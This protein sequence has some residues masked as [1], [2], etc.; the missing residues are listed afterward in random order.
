MRR[1][2]F[3]TLLGG[4]AVAWPL[5]AAAQDKGRVPRI[6]VLLWGAPDSDPYVGPLRQGLRDLGYV[7]G[8]NI[9]VEYR[10]AEGRS[11]RAAEQVAELVHRNVDVIV[12][13]TTPAA[14]A[15]KSGT[16][17][18]PIVL[19]P[20]ADPLAT[21]LVTSLARPGGNITGVSSISSELNAKRLE[22]LREILP[23]LSRMAFLGSKSDPNAET[24]LRETQAAA[25]KLGV[26]LQPVM[27]GGP[28][29][30]EGAFA[31]MV[32]G[33]AE[34][35]IVQPIF[36]LHRTR[37]AE[38]AA[39]HRLPTA[40]ANK[41]FAEAGCL[42][43]FGASLSESMRQAAVCVDKILKG[44]RPGELPVEQ[45]TKFE[46]VINLKTAKTLG[47]EIPPALLARADEVID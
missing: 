35:L 9:L 32:S 20:V 6:G 21:G 5:A 17:T 29:E 13:S 27:V 25:E 36:A 1:R 2:E 42:V 47:I 38:L 8:Q 19:A 3:I 33:Q 16:Q 40:A 24:F 46:V 22:L 12:A 28:E 30:F 4:A 10:F 7:E 15:A 44:A 11:D 43:S 45:P 37:I 39:Q 31:A 14:H 41:P 23:G 26:R 34:A 18:I